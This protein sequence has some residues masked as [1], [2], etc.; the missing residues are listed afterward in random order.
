MQKWSPRRHMEGL[1]KREETRGKRGITQ[2]DVSLRIE[3]GKGYKG[4]RSPL[5]LII[6]LC[7][8]DLVTST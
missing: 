5:I 4:E 6:Q 3:R 7:A 1:R 8:F 2:E